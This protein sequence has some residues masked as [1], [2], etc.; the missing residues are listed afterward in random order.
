LIF[1][2]SNYDQCRSNVAELLAWIHD[3]N[4]RRNLKGFRLLTL[5][6]SD[7]NSFLPLDFFLCSS[8]KPD[9][10]LQ[11]ITKEIDKRNCG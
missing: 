4:R 3:H 2:D 5:G 11:G 10:R 1:D 6:W 7:G 8:T 9:K